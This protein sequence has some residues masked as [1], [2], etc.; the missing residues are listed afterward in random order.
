MLGL[1]SIEVVIMSIVLCTCTLPK[2]NGDWMHVCSADTN[3]FIVTFTA[4]FQLEQ[5]SKTCKPIK[6]NIYKIKSHIGILNL[7]KK[8]QLTDFYVSILA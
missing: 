3:P 2:N 6:W 5:V 1:E 4:L 7:K 8:I